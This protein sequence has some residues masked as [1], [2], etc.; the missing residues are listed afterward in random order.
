MGIHHS[1]PPYNDTAGGAARLLGRGLWAVFGVGSV[2]QFWLD[3][4]D[5]SIQ[6]SSP[7]PKGKRRCSSHWG[8]R[9]DSESDE[10]ER[11]R[12]TRL[13]TSTCAAPVCPE[14]IHVRRAGGLCQPVTDVPP[15]IRTTDPS[16]SACRDRLRAPAS[17]PSIACSRPYIIRRLL[18]GAAAHTHPPSQAA[19]ARRHARATMEQQQQQQQQQ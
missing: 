19:A 15:H 17:G 14:S 3:E 6:G 13:D 12:P 10:T 16:E 7:H 4:H 5:G 9:P 8:G 2:D 18:V 11:T 1:S